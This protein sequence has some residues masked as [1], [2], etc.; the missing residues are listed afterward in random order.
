VAA[1]WRT[2]A[3]NDNGRTLIEADE[4]GWWYSAGLPDDRMVT[5]YVT[6]RAGAASLART[7]HTRTRIEQAGASL[8]GSPRRFDA[9]SAFSDPAAG[10]AAN[11][12]GWVA[13][14]DA[15]ASHDPLSARGIVSALASGEAAARAVLDHLGGDT[16]ALAGYASTNRRA[17]ARY[18][19]ERCAYYRTEQRWPHSPFWQ[20]RWQLPT[21]EQGG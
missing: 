9:G 8:A 18:L 20:R 21:L 12:A 7:V 5:V 11:G 19:I 15:A 10:T 17:F 1:H 3:G 6:D 16:T 2:Q 13:V 4:S 14:G